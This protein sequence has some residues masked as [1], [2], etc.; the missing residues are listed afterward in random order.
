MPTS[1]RKSELPYKAV[2]FDWRGTLFRDESDEDWLRASAASLGRELNGD[3][4][5]QLVR[6]LEAYDSHPD[7]VSARQR[8]DCSA[9]LHRECTLLH[10][11]L[12]G[13]DDELALAVWQRDGN[14]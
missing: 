7:V 13:F 14:L 11:R 2:L 5:A 8:A 6:A 12:A 9:E 10:L 1:M 4:A 3:N